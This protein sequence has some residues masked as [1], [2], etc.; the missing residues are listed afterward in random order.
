MTKQYRTKLIEQ[1]FPIRCL[2]RNSERKPVLEKA[3]DVKV[4]IHK[5]PNSSLISSSVECKYIYG[6]HSQFCRASKQGDVAEII[7]PYSFDLP[8]AIDEFVKQSSKA[9]KEDNGDR[10]GYDDPMPPIG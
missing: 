6:S 9:E 4:N 1:I 5:S 3:V 7:C 8:Y 2:G 10:F